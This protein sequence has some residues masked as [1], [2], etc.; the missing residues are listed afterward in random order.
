MEKLYVVVRADLSPG[1]Q[2]AQACHACRAFQ[3]EYRDLEESWYTT[4]NTIAVL[5]VPSET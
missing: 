3:A 4:S 2:I 1:L 5:S